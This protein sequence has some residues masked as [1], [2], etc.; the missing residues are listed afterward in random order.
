MQAL[1]QTL[2]YSIRRLYYFTFAVSTKLD[3]YYLRTHLSATL[4]AEFKAF[5]I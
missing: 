5:K 1:I 3:L 4:F 2:H